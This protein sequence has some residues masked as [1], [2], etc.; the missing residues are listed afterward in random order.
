MA[1]TDQHPRLITQPWS[2]DYLHT[3]P[4]PALTAGDGAAGAAPP[5]T[6]VPATTLQ[7]A[8]ELMGPNGDET[9]LPAFIGNF[10]KGLRHSTFG[11]VDEA[12]YQALLTAVDPGH[13]PPPPVHDPASFDAIPLYKQPFGR[14]LVNPQAG[15]ATDPQAP[16]PGAY[17][18]R[19]APSAT[20]A[21]A[22]AEAGELYWMTV[23]R[24][25]PFTA[26]EAD[27]TVERAA[28]DL[29]H[30][31]A[32]TVLHPSG[33]LTPRTLFRGFTPGDERGPYLSQFLLRD[34]PYGSLTISQR[35]QTVLPSVDYMTRYEDW[36][37]IQN[38][39]GGD[40]RPALDSERRY[41][42]T[43]RDLSHYVHVDALYEAYLNA[44]LILLGAGTVVDAG[45][46]YRYSHNQD[47]FGTLGGPHILSLVCEVATRA[48]KA[49]WYQKWMVHRRLRPE[50]YGGLVHLNEEGLLGTKKDYPLHND[51]F[52]REAIHAVR[53]RHGSYLLPMA[54]PEGSPMHPSYGAGH[55]TVAG[56]C[57]TILK[58]WFDGEVRVTNPVIPNAE[59]NALVPYR[60]PHHD[61]LTV[62]GELNKLAANIAIGRNM[63]GVHWR[64]DYTESVKLGE[65]V[66]LYLLRLQSTDYHERHPASS[67]STGEPPFFTLRTFDGRPVRV[68]G[69]EVTYADTGEAIPLPPNIAC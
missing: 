42:R 54:F 50:A 58:A 41:I 31:S 26:F 32:A 36:L 39:L 18:M 59:G 55:G 30:F 6:D 21:E 16:P 64:S 44:C 2:G 34:I 15:L 45:N 9:N 37:G 51:I 33:T 43:M 22:A 10:H 67:P 48:L 14:K 4:S 49:V 28:A 52:E 69:G 20:S 40:L 24:D 66:A 27:S 13:E 7:A 68:Q 23:L 56:A 8:P 65:Q 29:S 47:G 1:Q 35:Q 60:G 38:G 5:T 19:A 53:S 12:D 61:E 3:T 63:G 62:E 11:E 17:Q 25:V 46:P 57:V